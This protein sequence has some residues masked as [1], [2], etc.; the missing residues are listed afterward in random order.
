MKEV[1]SC[2]KP[3]AERSISMQTLLGEWW[4][5]L[6][7]LRGHWGENPGRSH[8]WLHFLADSGNLAQSSKNDNIISRN[9]SKNQPLSH[10]SVRCSTD[11]VSIK[12][13]C[14]VK[15]ILCIFR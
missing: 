14:Q 6:E 12:Q 4:V 9:D 7:R 10:H 1:S 13:P 2:Q 15:I 8:V 11:N 5:N 3:G